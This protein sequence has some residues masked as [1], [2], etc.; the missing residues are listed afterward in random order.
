MGPKAQHSY[1]QPISAETRPRTPAWRQRC[2]LSAQSHGRR[3]QTR[4]SVALPS[5]WQRQGETSA[6]TTPVREHL[7]DSWGR[8]F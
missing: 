2:R 8:I 4:N 5:I 3:T 1:R 6:T 7:P